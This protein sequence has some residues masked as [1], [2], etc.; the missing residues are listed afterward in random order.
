MKELKQNQYL[1]EGVVLLLRTGDVQLK[2]QNRSD[3]VVKERETIKKTERSNP[4]VND[5]KTVK[6]KTSNSA[7]KEREAQ[8][9]I[10]KRSNPA[11][12]E[13]EK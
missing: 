8:P 5:K 13:R 4:A 12:M 1:E 2:R 6:D 3:P 11:A 9:L 7:A 10:Q